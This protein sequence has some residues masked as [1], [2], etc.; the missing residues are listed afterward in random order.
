MKGYIDRL[1]E[2]DR[3][4][5]RTWGLGRLVGSSVVYWVVL[6]AVGLGPVARQYWEIRRR[7]GHGTINFTWSGSSLQMILFIVG[8]PLL[9]TLLW[10]AARPRRP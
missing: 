2:G 8:P 5:L 6:L 4:M 1:L 10:L 7:D 3:M 9:M